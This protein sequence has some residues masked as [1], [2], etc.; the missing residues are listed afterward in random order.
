MKALV[1]AV[2][3]AGVIG[4]FSCKSH[5]EAQ[6]TTAKVDKRYLDSVSYVLKQQAAY[7][8]LKALVYADSVAAAAASASTAPVQQAPSVNDSIRLNVSFY[9]P[10]SGINYRA[11]QK[12]DGF[13]T[14]Y[15]TD[16][17]GALT[18][19]KTAWGR[20]GEVD[21]CFKF[22][23]GF[24]NKGDSFVKQVKDLLVGQ[25]RINYKEFTT[26]RKPRN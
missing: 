23:K 17:P 21:Y 3:L 9:S 2:L 11:A 15:Q 16:N 10:G 25:D 26:C 22:N 18:M 6:S 4:I 12:L 14:Q 19:Y 24:E 13:V 20:E 8:S 7:D 1:S 5:K